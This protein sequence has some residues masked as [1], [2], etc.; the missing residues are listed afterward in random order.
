MAM[1]L[2]LSAILQNENTSFR[3]DSGLDLFL[4]FYNNGI[5]GQ[6]KIPGSVTPACGSRTLQSDFS[7]AGSLTE[8]VL[9]DS[10]LTELKRQSSDNCLLCSFDSWQE[11]EWD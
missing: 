11:D 5:V 8:T 3:L 7:S 4:S 6:G 2:P 1:H 10:V 9:T